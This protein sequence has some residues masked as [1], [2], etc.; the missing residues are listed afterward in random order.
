MLFST[1]EFQVFEW[2][3]QY[4]PLVATQKVSTQELKSTYESRAS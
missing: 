2:S 1:D 3:G 4:S